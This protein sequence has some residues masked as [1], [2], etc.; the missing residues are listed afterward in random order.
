MGQGMGEEEKE[1]SQGGEKKERGKVVKGGQ[2][3]KGKGKEGEISP[4]G[5]F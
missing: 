3:G 2:E 1:R 5:H 4:H